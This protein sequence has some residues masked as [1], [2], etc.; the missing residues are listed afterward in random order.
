MAGARLPGLL[1]IRVP[2]KLI[3]SD[4]GRRFGGGGGMAA[5]RRWAT[6]RRC[7]EPAIGASDGRVVSGG[8]GAPPEPGGRRRRWC[9]EEEGWVGR[10]GFGWV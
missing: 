9:E 10:A 8:D 1:A 7:G 5:T 4:H 2:M 6:P 3:L